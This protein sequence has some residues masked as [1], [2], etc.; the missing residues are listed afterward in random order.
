MSMFLLPRVRPQVAILRKKKEIEEKVSTRFRAGKG[1]ARE[2]ESQRG[3]EDE[4]TP[5]PNWRKDQPVSKGR[6]QVVKKYNRK[7]R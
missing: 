3:L 7:A 1:R 5:S 6:R 4:P 2:E